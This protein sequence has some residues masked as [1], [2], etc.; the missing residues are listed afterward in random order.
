M[1]ISKEW[2]YR[3]YINREDMIIHAPYEPEMEFY[4]YVKSGDLDKVN[5]Y[6]K[7]DFTSIQGLGKLSDNEIRNF[8]YHFIITAAMVSRACIDAGLSLEQA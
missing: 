4:S 8:R 3:E 1:T 6:L 2:V 5:R 7:R